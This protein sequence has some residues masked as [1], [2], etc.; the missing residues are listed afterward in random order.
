M[1]LDEEPPH[2]KI[3]VLTPGKDMK[4]SDII[5]CLR[6]QGYLVE[7]ITDPLDL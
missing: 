5:N 2:C 3:P 7:E 6:D 1:V 4:V